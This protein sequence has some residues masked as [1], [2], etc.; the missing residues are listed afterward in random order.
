M[1]VDGYRILVLLDCGEVCLV[2]VVH[3]L[4]DGHAG[5]GHPAAHHAGTERHCQGTEELRQAVVLLLI[6]LKH[7]H[8]QILCII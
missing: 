5:E 2:C 8:P 1:K 3:H 4:G 6:L 7:A